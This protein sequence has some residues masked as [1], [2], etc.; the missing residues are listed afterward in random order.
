MTNMKYWRKMVLIPTPSPHHSPQVWIRP[1]VLAPFF[2]LLTQTLARVEEA[3]HACNMIW[4]GCVPLVLEFPNY[5]HSYTC[6]YTCRWTCIMMSSWITCIC[7]DSQRSSMLIIDPR[8]SHM[9]MDVHVHCS[10]VY[11][12]SIADVKCPHAFNNFTFTTT[13]GKEYVNSNLWGILQ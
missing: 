4:S 3:P 7:M 10:R 11:G 8:T 6:A 9:S 1:W 13:C 2:I 12:P 5:I